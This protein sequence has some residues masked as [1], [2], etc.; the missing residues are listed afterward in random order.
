MPSC[1][2]CNPYECGGPCGVASQ[3]APRKKKGARSEEEEKK[4]PAP[5]IISPWIQTTNRC[6]MRCPYCYVP[7]SPEDMTDEVYRFIGEW[8]REYGERIFI[9]LAGGE[10]FLVYEKWKDHVLDYLDSGAACD[11][12]TN[13]SVL[14][15]EFKEGFAGR[16][17]LSVS[18]DGI[19]KSK[20]FVNGK[21]SHSVVLGNIERLKEDFQIYILT[22]IVNQDIEEL[23]E[24]ANYV[25]CNNFN[26][27]LCTDYFDSDI[28]SRGDIIIGIM[29]YLKDIGYDLRRLNFNQIGSPRGCTAGDNIFAIGVDGSLYTCQTL[30]G[31]ESCVIGHIGNDDP[32]GV[33]A[34]GRHSHEKL[35]NSRCLKCDYYSLC[36]GWCPLHF[37][38][39]KSSC[40]ILK[41][42]C[43]YYQEMN[44]R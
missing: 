36:H 19:N 13:L 11:I 14:P 40:S 16:V 44:D 43:R 26:W 23:Q 41:K 7:K 18:L 15:R 24:V 1:H 39:G 8:V 29:D 6:N 3:V 10:P 22:T 33:L 5:D 28:S 25:A 27:R 32:V 9:R 4:L 37:K 21:S 42:V 34:G 30:I 31:K 17:N 20:P 38:P 12:I 35:R 2:A